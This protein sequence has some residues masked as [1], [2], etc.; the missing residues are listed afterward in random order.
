M[1]L[2]EAHT[3][4]RGELKA[5]AAVNSSSARGDGSFLRLLRS[6]RGNDGVL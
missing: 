6:R 1:S 3:R 4:F 2:D 5:S